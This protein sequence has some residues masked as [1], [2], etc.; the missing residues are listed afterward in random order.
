M[1]ALDE[2]ILYGFGSSNKALDYPGVLRNGVASVAEAF[3][4]YRV[5][6]TRGMYSMDYQD[7]VGREGPTLEDLKAAGVKMSMGGRTS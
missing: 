2:I 3:G 1:A 4:A 7:G 6:V 5:K